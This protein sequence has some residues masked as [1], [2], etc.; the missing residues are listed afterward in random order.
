MT[1]R[2]HRTKSGRSRGARATSLVIAEVW[3]TTFASLANGT[4]QATPQP[5][6][7]KS[8]LFACVSSIWCPRLR[9]CLTFPYRGPGPAHY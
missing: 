9:R 8:S 3:E 2:T 1:R 5:N 7:E 6:A 4:A